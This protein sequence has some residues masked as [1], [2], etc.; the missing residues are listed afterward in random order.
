[1]GR[2]RVLIVAATIALLALLGAGIGAY[3]WLDGYRPLSL[4][5]G[6]IAGSAHQ[7]K[8][9]G[10]IVE[11]A[12]GSGGKTVI[13][14]R[15]R[16]GR[17]YFVGVTLWNSG[18]FDV[19]L[20][21]V[22]TSQYGPGGGM[23]PRDLRASP[24][25]RPGFMSQTRL[26]DS[27]PTKRLV[28]KARGQ[29]FVW[30]GFR[31]RSCGPSD[32]QYFQSLDR[33]PFRFRYLGHFTRRQEIELPFA[34]TLVCRAPLPRSNSILEPNGDPRSSRAARAAAERADARQA[35]PH[36]GLRRARPLV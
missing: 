31:M 6:G 33:V 22:D 5:S 25:E 30:V 11:P 36:P 15:F 1:M 12:M 20:L 23:Y 2:R 27:T 9:V 7:S 18:R 4:N 34:L 17:D 10:A 3:E 16:R 24:P 29:R 35:R 21:G 28:I 13:F 19:T 26:E 8:G 32:S 14:P